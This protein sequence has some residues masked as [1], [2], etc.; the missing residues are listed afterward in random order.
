MSSSPG[1]T[2]AFLPSLA[3]GTD[4]HRSVPTGI[5]PVPLPP[6]SPGTRHDTTTRGITMSRFQT[7]KSEINAEEVCAPLLAYEYEYSSYCLPEPSSADEMNPTRSLSRGQGEES[8]VHEE[9]R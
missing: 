3:L 2:C 6:P 9:Q 1:D 4:A 7:M 8:N 5:R